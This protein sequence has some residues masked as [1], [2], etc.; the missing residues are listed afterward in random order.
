MEETK[1]DREQQRKERV[2]GFAH[3]NFRD[4]VLRLKV[5]EFDLNDSKEQ[6]FFQL[7]DRIENNEFEKVTTLTNAVLKSYYVCGKEKEIFDFVDAGSLRVKK[8][9]EM[10]NAFLSDY[11]LEEKVE[12][13][14]PNELYE[15]ISKTVADKLI[16]LYGSHIYFP[17]MSTAFKTYEIKRK[18]GESLKQRGY[19][20][21]K[22]DQRF[23][24]GNPK[25]QNQNTK[26]QNQILSTYLKIV[27]A[28]IKDKAYTNHI[29]KNLSVEQY[30]EFWSVVRDTL[31]SLE[32]RMLN[33]TKNSDQFVESKKLADTFFEEKIDKAY[34]KYTKDGRF[35]EYYN[36][37]K[38]S[39]G[40]LLKGEQT[41]QDNEILK[42]FY[43]RIEKLN[44]ALK[45]KDEKGQNFP[46]NYFACMP[47]YPT[48]VFPLISKIEKSEIL[49]EE[50]KKVLSETK[51]LIRLTFPDLTVINNGN[52]CELGR[53]LRSF[54]IKYVQEHKVL[55]LTDE[56]S[57]NKFVLQV[58]Q[59]CDKY[60]LPRNELCIKTVGR[61]VVKGRNPI[62]LEDQRD[63]QYEGKNK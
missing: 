59:I 61:D 34:Q 42:E 54:R 16:E 51:S 7:F 20:S 22:K 32:S 58:E 44:K 41:V 10:F 21:N 26:Y 43:Q 13:K 33:E 28:Y 49:N 55:D 17:L 53:A 12:C 3:E 18:I 37:L 47:I 8:P 4:W 31:K 25:E 11:V 52:C 14:T 57:Y 50:Q 39:V 1:K 56:D 48:I 29:S 24:I 9:V 63:K 15:L 46:A 19:V 40:N 6:L 45:I 23:L 5:N 35:G 2:L 38:T 36:E 27:D 60:N 30:N 62:V